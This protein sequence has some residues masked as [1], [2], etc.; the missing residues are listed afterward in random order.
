MLMI[1]VF[2]VDY[3][4]VVCISGGTMQLCKLGPGFGIF[5]VSKT[6]LVVKEKCYLEA[7]VVFAGINVKITNERR[8]YIWAL[9]L[10]Q[11]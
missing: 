5:S 10:D 2:V 8:P 1:L 7:E 6:W 3:L 9:Q 11:V 4:V